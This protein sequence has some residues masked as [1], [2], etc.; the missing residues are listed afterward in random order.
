[1]RGPDIPELAPGK[2]PH[3]T[4]GELYG[5]YVH[6]MGAPS[7]NMMVTV[8]NL[9]QNLQTAWTQ[10]Q[11]DIVQIGDIAHTMA[12]KTKILEQKPESPEF[13][14]HLTMAHDIEDSYTAQ[15]IAQARLKADIRAFLKACA[16][17][18]IKPSAAP[19]LANFPLLLENAPA[20]P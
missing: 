10:A 20:Q 3:T 19:I 11:L 14:K 5:R 15:K 9:A 6:S 8:L 18:A 2:S 12:Q 4:L 17:P 13:L 7:A 1:M 16:D